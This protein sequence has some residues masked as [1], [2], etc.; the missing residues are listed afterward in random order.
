MTGRDLVQK[1]FDSL[2][3]KYG[4]RLLRKIEPKVR[5][6]VDA[7]YDGDEFSSGT[8]TIM[9]SNE[10]ITVHVENDDFDMVVWAE[11][12][13]EDIQSRDWNSVY[14]TVDDV[15]ESAALSVLDVLNKNN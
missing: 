12:K 3:D 4:E 14:R 13:S 15:S 11:N 7:L 1:F 5:P 2:A 10:D 6:A 8:F 9:H